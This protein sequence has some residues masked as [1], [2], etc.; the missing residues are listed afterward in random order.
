MS[1]D[2]GITFYDQDFLTFS[3][4]STLLSENIRRILLTRRGERIN[5]PSFGSDIMK[6]IFMPDMK[7]TDL[8]AEIK[9]SIERCEPRVTVLECTL[10][11]QEDGAVGIELK[12][13]EKNTLTV[14]DVSV[15]V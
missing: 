6:Y 14:D 10:S 13:L 7:V 11:S 5:N 1:E 9:N 8:V 3:D 12:V 2:K 4:Q 15:T